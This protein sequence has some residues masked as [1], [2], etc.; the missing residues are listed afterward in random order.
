MRTWQMAEIFECKYLNVIK[1][2]VE[3][4]PRKKNYSQNYWVGK[5]SHNCILLSL[6][7]ILKNSYFEKGSNIIGV[8]N[9]RAAVHGKRKTTF[10]NQVKIRR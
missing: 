9:S 10:L 7:L 5:T 1:E 4:F 8:A 6:G 2:S 3:L